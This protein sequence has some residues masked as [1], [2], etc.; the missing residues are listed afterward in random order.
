MIL[1]LRILPETILNTI[2]QVFDCVFNDHQD[3]LLFFGLMFLVTLGLLSRVRQ[4]KPS[5]YPS[6]GLR[7]FVQCDRIYPKHWLIFTALQFRP[8]YRYLWKFL[9]HEPFTYPR[10]RVIP[11]VD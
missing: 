5:L 8:M 6:N 7:T 11:L 2:Y 10:G 4:T 1:Y 9:W 3:I